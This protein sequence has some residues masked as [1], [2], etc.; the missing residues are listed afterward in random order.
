MSDNIPLPSDQGYLAWT[1][2]PA[3]GSTTGTTAAT[4][5]LYMSALYLRTAT[6]ISTISWAQ[7][8]AGTSPTSSENWA[9]LYSSTG[10]LLGSAGIDATVTNGN[11]VSTASI[12]RTVVNPGFCW[13]GLLY[14]ATPSPAL[15]RASENTLVVV[16][17]GLATSAL[18]FT[19]NGTALTSL[20]GSI[21]PSGNSATIGNSY[22]A[23]LS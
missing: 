4:G 21:T 22:W 7:L 2:D 10:T 11:T 14:N 9:G 8:T 1:F 13:V 23:A 3:A 17:A 6:V 5:T 18:R 16:N 19:S 20:P 15:I 12:T